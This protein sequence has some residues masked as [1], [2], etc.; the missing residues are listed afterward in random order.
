L[1]IEDPAVVKRGGLVY[2]E[3]WVIDRT[4]FRGGWVLV[5]GAS[6]TAAVV[7][8]GRRAVLTIDWSYIRNDATPLAL[9]VAAGDLRLGRLPAASPGVWR[10]SELPPSAWPPGAPLRLSTVAP[11]GAPARNGL[12]IDRVEISWRE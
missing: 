10:R 1:E 3:Q 7:P 5:E 11:P 6:A 8:G 4:R 9:E 12:V 2:P